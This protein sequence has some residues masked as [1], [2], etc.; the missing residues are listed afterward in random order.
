MKIVSGSAFEGKNLIA[1][2]PV[3]RLVIDFGDL[4]DHS[5]ARLGGGF[6]AHL[7][8]FLT[9]LEAH[10]GAGKRGEDPFAADLSQDES[11]RL[12]HVVVRI[13]LALQH[14]A[15]AEVSYATVDTNPAGASGRQELIFAHW[16]GEFGVT[17]GR[18]ALAALGQLLNFSHAEGNAQAAD[19]GRK[20]AS[21]IRLQWLD[22]STAALVREAIRRDIPWRRVSPEARFVQFGYGCWQETIR[23]TVTQ[24]SSSNSAWMSTNK[25]VTSRVLAEAGLPVPRQAAIRI[26]S[27]VA[28]AAEQAVG[29]AD[30]I[31]YPVV[32]KPMSGKEALGIGVN[33]RD[34]AALR[35]AVEE[36]AKFEN[37]IIL[38]SF[39]TGDDHRVLIVDG[40]MIAAAKRIPAHIVGDGRQSVAQL[41]AEANRDPRRG[42]GFEKILVRLELNT[43]AERTLSDQGLNGDSVAAAGQTVYLRNTA[44]IA[45][46]GTA[47]DVTDI[48][49]PD[50]RRAAVRAAQVL[51]LGVAGVD[52]LSTDISRSY[53]ENGAAICEVNSSPGLRP[54]WLGDDSR[55]VVGPIMDSI[56]PPGAPSRVPIAAITGT[57]GK[58]T[59]TRMVA[60]IL[61]HAGHAV[62][63]STS[64]GV[65]IQ[66]ER[67]AEGDMA[68]VTGA[69]MVLH[70]PEIDIAVLETARRGIITRGLAVDWCDVG[71][72]LNID[73]DHIGTDGVRDIEDLAR[74]K[75]LVAMAARKLVVLNADDPRCVAMAGRSAA[76]R[77]CYVTMAPDHGAIAKPHI[78]SGGMAVSLRPDKA[79]DRG[80]SIEFHNNG[81]TTKILPLSGLPTAMNG[82][83]MHNVQNAMFALA[84]AHG[85]G[86]SFAHIRAGLEALSCSHADTPGRFDM[87]T[88]LPF[89]VVLD[90]AHNAQEFRAVSTVIKQLECKGRRIVAFATPGNRSDQHFANLATA[91]AQSA[92]DHYICFR[93]NDLRGRGLSEVPERLRDGLIEAGV[94]AECISIVPPE[95][96]AVNAALDMAAPDDIVALL[97]SD[98][99]KVW[100]MLGARSADAR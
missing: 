47:S 85:L 18:V 35:K 97:Y 29:M 90:Y 65:Y 13:A 98:H 3:V 12:G 74:V 87:F 54:H 31:G 52:F 92:F 64:D 78:A 82:K 21:L 62:G 79:D 19:F 80:S 45:T 60:R 16:G 77:I 73:D 63:C 26:S 41:V 59:T 46:G 7:V 99:D 69:R 91:A 22:I 24:H 75:S 86:A 14:V 57:N 70:N 56:Y 36:A 17:A 84:I 32:V 23:E 81:Q 76:Q 10:G 71:A 55:D 33:L 68:G 34:A 28:E 67:I 50:N 27:N 83:A 93:R 9:E 4:S 30:K 48:V 38:E 25:A 39:V 40:K 100:D 53:H 8:E 5:P 61:E 44:N 95:D 51:G 15:G 20:V 2:V 49:H 66:R 43:Q 72:V 11:L 37:T 89:R 6:I 94:A 1:P 96:D 58:T 42:S 88:G